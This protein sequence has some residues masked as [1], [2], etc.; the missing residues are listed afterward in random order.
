[1]MSKQPKTAELAATPLSPSSAAAA[2]DADTCPRCDW[3]GMLPDGQTWCD[4]IPAPAAPAPLALDD[5]ALEA[6]MKSLPKYMR[7]SVGGRAELRKFARKVLA[8]DHALRDDRATRLLSLVVG[9]IGKRA[10]S[11][12]NAPGHGHSVTGVWDSD[13]GE[14]AGKPCAWCAIWNEARE[15]V[16]GAGQA[17]GARP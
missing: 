1:M 8:A 6:L 9:E 11:N 14:L 17:P 3:T 16:G 13:N 12:G 10:G 15:L 2:L 5:A 7:D 4:H